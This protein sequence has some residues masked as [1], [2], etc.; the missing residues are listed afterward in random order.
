MLARGVGVF[1]NEQGESNMVK[2][3]VAMTLLST[4]PFSDPLFAADQS[5]ATLEV[6][7]V[8]SADGPIALFSGYEKMKTRDGSSIYKVSFV[9][10]FKD[11]DGV[12]IKNVGHVASKGRLTYLTQD[13]TVEFRDSAFGKTLA[14]YKT[15]A[16]QNSYQNTVDLP[17]QN[18]FTQPFVGR[19]V[20]W[21][22]S[23]RFQ[24]LATETANKSKLQAYAYEQDGVSY[25][26]TTWTQLPKLPKNLIG[27]VALRISYPHK[28]IGNSTWY[29]VESTARERRAK[30]D[31][32]ESPSRNEDV[33]RA[34]NLFVDQFIQDLTTAS[35]VKK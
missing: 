16:A 27:H 35:V 19:E 32:W 8:A 29:R 4:L 23:S 18:D 12:Y 34:S 6:A 7:A 21:E 20:R 25:L 13:S 28:K 3:R 24:E 5:P 11:T 33:Q 1:C 17:Q 15:N 31:K 2:R 30:E 22:T 14:V 9:Y 10:D 26:M